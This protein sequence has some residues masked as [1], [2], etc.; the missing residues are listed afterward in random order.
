MDVTGMT[1]PWQE[2]RSTNVV[3]TQ[4]IPQFWMV[5][6]LPNGIQPLADTFQSL[7]EGF[8]QPPTSP[9]LGILIPKTA[10]KETRKTVWP[11]MS[12]FRSIYSSG[13]GSQTVEIYSKAI[14]LPRLGQLE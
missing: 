10:L 3:G 1:S 12:K 6:L 9:N 14:I 13:F 11:Q 8:S 5:L 7:L 4:Q 2:F